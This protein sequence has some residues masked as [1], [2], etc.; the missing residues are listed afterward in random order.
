MSRDGRLIRRAREDCGLSLRDVAAR[1]S[2]D[3]STVLRW[4]QTG[5]L[6][7]LTAW[8]LAK[9]Y[10]CPVAA[11]ADEAVLARWLAKRAR[12]RSRITHP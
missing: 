1:M 7:F 6:W 4:E 2:V 9:V 5:A 8:S 3:P 10:G 11:F 12:V